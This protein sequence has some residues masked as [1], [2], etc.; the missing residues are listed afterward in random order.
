MWAEPRLKAVGMGFKEG[1][2]WVSKPPISPSPEFQSSLPG[3]PQLGLVPLAGKRGRP[4]PI[5]S[6]EPEASR[7]RGCGSQGRLT[8]ILTQKARARE[9]MG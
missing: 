4:S 9:R 1:R 6:Q 3:A 2:I 5:C 7:A 8:N